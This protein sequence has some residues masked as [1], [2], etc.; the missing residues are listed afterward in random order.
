MQHG[1]ALK[2]AVLGDPMHGEGMEFLERDLRFTWLYLLATCT[3]MVYLISRYTPLTCMH[4]V[5]AR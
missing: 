4:G 2:V 1:T 5:S 3:A